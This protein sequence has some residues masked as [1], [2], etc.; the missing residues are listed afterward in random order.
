MQAGKE[1]PLKGENG[2]RYTVPCTVDRNRMAEKQVV[3]FRVGNVYRDS[4]LCV[5]YNDKCISRVKKKVMAPGEMEQVILMKSKLE[6]FDGL[7]S[8]TIRI[9]QE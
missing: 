1:I 2:V 6:A 4:F 7:E 8:I 9:E 3:R 5:Y